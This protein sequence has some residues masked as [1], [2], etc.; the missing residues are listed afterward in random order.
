MEKVISSKKR[1][2]TYKGTNISMSPRDEKKQ[3]KKKKVKIENIKKEKLNKLRGSYINILEKATSPQKIYKSPKLD[4]K[5]RY[6]GTN[7]KATDLQV[8]RLEREEE[9]K[10]E[11][12]Q[13]REKKRVANNKIAAKKMLQ[14][15]KSIPESKKPTKVASKNPK[16]KE[17]IVLKKG[18]MT[19]RGR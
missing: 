1:K 13:D 6:K 15:I 9:R 4:K 3:K 5:G 7:I 16:G 10:A 8:K 14:T 11:K 12:K 2:A 17:K 18:G 19:R